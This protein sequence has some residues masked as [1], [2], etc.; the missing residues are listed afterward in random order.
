MNLDWTVVPFDGLDVHALHAVLKLRTDVFVVEQRCINPEVDGQDPEALHVL[1]R[2]PDGGLVAYARVL[3]PHGEGPPHI[4]RVVVHPGYRGRGLATALM[5][6]ALKAV[7]D[8][9]GSPR[10]AVAAQTYLEGFYG[11]LGYVRQGADYDWDGIP[12]VDML[13][14]G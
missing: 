14:N 4:G 10:S 12:H 1:G 8:H 11:R 5:Q 3:P 2:L 6:Q 13:L 7:E 9:Y